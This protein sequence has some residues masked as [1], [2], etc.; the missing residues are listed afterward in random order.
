MPEQSHLCC[1]CCFWR[2]T[3]LGSIGMRLIGAGG[4]SYRASAVF[5]LDPQVQFQ[6]AIDPVDSFVVL[7]VALHVAQIQK[8]Q[9]KA[10]GAL[11]CRQAFQPFG[12]I[13]ILIAQHGAVSMTCLADLERPTC[14]R[15]TDSMQCDRAHSHLSTL[16]RLQRFFPRASFRR[17][18]CM[19]I[20]AY[21][22][23]SRQI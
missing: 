5:G 23:L 9:A 21:I 19:L 20:S 1:W 17:S 4:R 3:D 10:P 11:I 8:T 16:R 2:M 15:D 22:F 14:Q 7:T 12:Y 18:F 6:L 13:C